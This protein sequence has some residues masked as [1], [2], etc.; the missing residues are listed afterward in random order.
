MST[1]SPASIPELTISVRELR[2]QPGTSKQVQTVFQAPGDLGTEVIGIPEGAAVELELLLESVLEGVLVTGTASG[3]ARGEC[4]RCLDEVTLP[5]AVTFQEL[6]VYPERV[7]AAEE[8]G[9][10]TSD[11]PVVV[12]D[13]INLESAVRDAVVLALPFQPLCRDDCPGLCPECGFPLRD[14]PG[15]AHRQVDAR[16]A[17]LQ[18][19]LDVEQVE[20]K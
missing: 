11:E 5:L 3:T 8:S 7:L 16:W 9:D 10:D 13:A 12:D 14:D 4:V 20:G 2:R 19:L 15:H 1:A 6:H 17:A 18:D